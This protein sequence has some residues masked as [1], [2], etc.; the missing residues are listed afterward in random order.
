MN[1]YGPIFRTIEPDEIV[2]RHETVYPMFEINIDLKLEENTSDEK[3]NVFGFAVENSTYPN[4]DSQIPAVYLTPDNELQICM[5]IDGA[6]VCELTS[7]ITVDTWF[8]LWIEQWCWVDEN[9]SNISWCTVYTMINDNVEWFWYN[10]TPMTYR[11]V[12]G[13]VGNTYGGEFQSASG[14]GKKFVLYSHESR[15]TPSDK[16]NAVIDASNIDIVQAVNYA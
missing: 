2:F 9:N 3:Q 1:A 16:L 6:T 13:I 14:Y 11:N 8:N 15:V 7:Q 4:V 5:Q 10:R 12:D